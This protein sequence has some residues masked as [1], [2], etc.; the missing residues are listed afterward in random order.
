MAVTITSDTLCGN[1]R[2]IEWTSTLPTP[3]Y[4]VYVDGLLAQTTTQTAAQ[5]YV[6]PGAAPV[7][8]VLDTTDPP[9]AAFSGYKKL[10][11]YAL[12]DA[13]SYAIE[14]L[15][16]SVWT[17]QT[18]ILSTGATIYEWQTPFLDDCEL[19]QF[20]VIATDAHGNAGEHVHF[21]CYMIRHPNPPVCIYTYSNAAHTVTINV[22]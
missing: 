5:F 20:R 17:A 7:V 8:Q 3:T 9:A 13:A 19:H 12:A 15:I 16:D 1:T 6:D 11:W 18:T 2:F 10:S 22:S 14:R 21:E 4:Y